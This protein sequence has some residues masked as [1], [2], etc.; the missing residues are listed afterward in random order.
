MSWF[1]IINT[2]LRK[3]W[4]V[5][6]KIWSKIWICMG[7]IILENQYVY[8]FTLKCPAV[9]PYQKPNLIIPKIA[10]QD[11]QLK[12]NK[13]ISGVLWISVS[14][15]KLGIS[16]KFPKWLIQK[17]TSL[18]TVSPNTGYRFTWPYKLHPTFPYILRTLT[19]LW[20]RCAKWLD[21]FFKYQV[22]ISAPP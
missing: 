4:E 21:Q 16:Q 22:D 7:H 17:S 15:G 9:H 19:S 13:L 8:G 2:N 6:V 3:K 18:H 20:P 12:L 10:V 14:R 11:W 1:F 5:L